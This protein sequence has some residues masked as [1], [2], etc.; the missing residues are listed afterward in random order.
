[1][2]DS[3]GNTGFKAYIHCSF[4]DRLSCRKLRQLLPS[5]VAAGLCLLVLCLIKP[6]WVCINYLVLFYP[7]IP[8]YGIENFQLRFLLFNR[9]SAR[10]YF[11]ITCEKIKASDLYKSSI[12]I[13]THSGVF[14][15]F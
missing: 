5:F 9:S 15:H 1:M 8:G 14:L 13:T 6:F 12:I 4:L 3:I 2:V 7:S 11:K 10:F